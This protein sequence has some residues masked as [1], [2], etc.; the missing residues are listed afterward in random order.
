LHDVTVEYFTTLLASPARMNVIVYWDGPYRR[1]VKQTTDQNRR[2]NVDDQ[3]HCLANYL[4]TG[5]IPHAL[6]SHN[7]KN[8]C[9]ACWWGRHFPKSRLWL[10]QIKHTIHRAINDGQ[11]PGVICIDE[12][13]MVI[14]RDASQ[15]SDSFVV[16][17][18]TDFCFF[19][20]V[21]YIS[22]ATMF[23][24]A[25]SSCVTASVI[26]RK[27]LVI[28]LGLPDEQS[29]VE[30]AIAAGN[31]YLL[32]PYST[33]LDFPNESRF[34][35]NT[36]ITLGELREILDFVRSQGQ[37]FHWKYVATF[38][39]E[40]SE[41][42]KKM[43][44]IRSLY[45]LESVEFYPL[46]R[47]D[48]YAPALVLSESALREGKCQISFSKHEDCDEESSVTYIAL[49]NNI[50]AP[51]HTN[52]ESQ[53]SRP[54]IPP[55]YDI[56]N[57]KINVATDASLFDA[58]IRCLSAFI[59]AS[60]AVNYFQDVCPPL[61]KSF[62]RDDFRQEHI[63]NFIS[64]AID[65]KYTNKKHLTSD[66]LLDS[67]IREPPRAWR[68]SLDDT[69]AVYLIEKTISIAID[70]NFRSTL[71][72]SGSPRLLFCQYRFHK[73]LYW[74]R[75]TKGKGS[76]LLPAT[77]PLQQGE[78]SSE[79]GTTQ[80][81]KIFVAPTDA[82]LPSDSKLVATSLVPLRDKLPIDEHELTILD[83][84]RKDRVCVIQGETGCGKSTRV[85]IM[86]L[87]TPPPDKHYT[88]SKLFLSV[89][90]RIAATT[91]VERLRKVE[92]DLKTSFA[93]RMGHG[94]QMYES[95]S[96]RAWVVTT[97]FLARRLIC[98][99]ER[100]DSI[101]HLI[102]DEIHERCVN[103]D[104]LC[105]LCRRLLQ[106]NKNI[107]LVLMS[108]T[109]A[110]SL[111]QS[112]FG[113]PEPPIY[114]GCRRFSVDE[115]FLEDISHRV[116]LRSCELALLKRILVKYERMNKN[117][118]PTVGLLDDV[119]S[120]VSSMAIS[121]GKPGSSVL[122]FVAGMFDILAITERIENSVA[123]T[124][125]RYKCIPMHSEIPLE[126]QAAAFQRAASDEV[127]VI[128]A[129]NAAE[130]SIT[131]PDVDHVICLGLHKQIEYNN[132]SHRQMLS[133]GWISQSSAIQRAGRTGRVRHGSVYRIYTKNFFQQ[134][135]TRFDQ[136]EICRMPLDSVILT[137]KEMLPQESVTELLVECLEPPNILTID[138]S[139]A[140]LC[141][142][143]FLTEPNDEGDITELGKFVA[144]LGFDMTLGLLISFGIR[145]GVGAEAIQ[146]AAVL[147]FP[148][149]PWTIASPPI[150]AVQEYNGA[151]LGFVHALLFWLLT[152]DDLVPIFQKYSSQA[153]FRNAILMLACSPTR[154]QL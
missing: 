143:G 57:A 4:S 132:E 82:M 89:P 117:S 16:A 75:Q 109:L 123:A 73:L 41:V 63:D 96:T 112:Y 34:R 33:C 12:A 97:G 68:P 17:D 51:P 25:E 147:S 23:A 115:I 88:E 46:V 2:R 3:W 80:G 42:A 49:Q 10:S 93:L 125:K 55:D 154:L 31:D 64:L 45:N 1:A 139:F 86:I 120:I 36:Y 104:I 130:S 58:I 142:N 9:C 13:D 85:P 59:G 106:H 127:K 21:N 138:R 148:Q 32:D 76:Y 53:G 24:S 134:H 11:I 107:R 39:E 60:D 83:A 8:A 7:G 50:C 133:H 78:A 152:Y 6:T 145:F 135:M 110:S 52:S 99:P 91:L 56:S 87:R 38:Q 67:E 40:S 94:V 90:R 121:L 72:T 66:S 18:D 26:R 22:L 84:I 100:L 81:K 136:G 119:H 5:S 101:S 126:D 29:L 102:L 103:T 37:G 62:R 114:V 15:L 44:F 28:A 128:I 140:S 95:E 54:L 98:N 113:V 19:P 61:A 116:Q 137:L 71:V 131:L 48:P 20:D 74:L 141:D 105:L 70:L 150:H 47:L 146:M 79:D 69:F 108:A 77:P 151:F 129:T 65:N 149:T 35:C 27:E 92:P 111:Y 144:W 14:A 153:L 124:S 43:H 122:I 30:V 118:T